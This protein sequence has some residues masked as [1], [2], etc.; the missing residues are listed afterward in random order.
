[1]DEYMAM[2]KIFAGNF[3]P[4]TFMYCSGQLLAINTNQALFSLIGTFYGGNGVSTF[5]LPNLN[6]RAPIGIG[7]MPGGSTYVLGQAAGTETVTLLQSN[8]PPHSHP[9]S[10]LTS[11]STQ[12]GNAIAAAGDAITPENNFLALSPKIGSGPNATQL[13]T[14]ATAAAGSPVKL[15]GGAITTTTSGNTTNSGSGIPISI[16]QPYLAVAY[17]ITTQ[18]IYPSRN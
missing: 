9:I 14:Y 3:A 8:L 11:S 18:G 12:A 13:K 15:G 4:R 6:G 17:V 16:M 2:I 10:G 5:A 7:T 1:M